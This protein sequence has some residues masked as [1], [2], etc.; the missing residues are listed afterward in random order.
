MLTDLRFELA[1]R[2]TNAECERFVGL[3]CRAHMHTNWPAGSQ[4]T[5]PGQVP[6]HNERFPVFPSML[7]RVHSLVHLLTKPQ[8][9]PRSLLGIAAGLD[10]RLI[11]FITVKAQLSALPLRSCV[12]EVK[13]IT[14]GARSHV[15]G[16]TPL[17]IA[18]RPLAAQAVPLRG[19]PYS[20]RGATP[21]LPRFKPG[22][23]SHPC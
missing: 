15:Y 10:V 4:S 5:Y 22:A 7:E 18:R 11:R 17:T 6:R 20:G 13:D 16:D 19:E 3:R 14:F 1:A 8:Q 2:S 23:A 21:A 9:W 12:A